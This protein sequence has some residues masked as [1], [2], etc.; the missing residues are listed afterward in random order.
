MVLRKQMILLGLFLTLFAPSAWSQ[1]LFIIPV[2]GPVEP[3]MAAFVKRSINTALAQD[4]DGVLVFSLDTFG[5]R[6]DAAL[7]I[8]DAILAVPEGKTVSYVEKRAISAGALIALAGDVLV[9]KT[10]SLMGDCAPMI[11]TSE[12]QKEVGEKVQTVLRAQ[13]RALAKQN[14]YP[15][16]L[17]ESMVTKSMV[18][19]RVSLDG[20]VQYMD[21]SGWDDLTQKQKKRV[22]EKK[23]LVSQGELL[24]M[25]DAEALALGFS[26]KSVQ[27]LDQAVQYLGYSG[28]ERRGL[29]ES[30]SESLVRWLQPLLPFLMI[31][32]MGALYTEIKAPGFGI[33][34]I[35]GVLCLGLVFFNQSLVGLAQAT[36]F[37]LL[38]LGGLL[39]LVELFVLPGFGIAG[40]AGILVLALS[41]VLAFQGFVLPDPELP[42]E[43]KLML[44]NA[45]MVAGSGLAALVLSLATVRFVL[46]TVSRVVPGPYLETTLE[47]ATTHVEAFD[48]IEPGQTGVALTPLRPSGKIRIKDENYHAQTRGEFIDANTP[49]QVEGVEQNHIIVRADTLKEKYS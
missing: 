32:G 21:Q 18:V 31:I 24:T 2:H 33:P 14:G 30:W 26:R 27:T 25:D 45:A 34:G 17:A 29:T 19:Y 6:V 15:E 4:P 36:E 9:M 49:I 7:D 28:Y 10:G 46:P 11:Q 1:T 20:K 16:L 13:F 39:I 35:I 42:W 12:G 40:I 43:G 37:L 5:G 48:A 3:G 41:L 47:E 23:T 38:I 8:V 22:T 44:H